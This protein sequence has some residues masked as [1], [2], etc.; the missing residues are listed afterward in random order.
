MK[1]AALGMLVA[2]AVAADAFAHHSPIVFDRSRE[3]RIE[4][5]VTEFKWSMPHSWIHLDVADA[6]GKVATWSVEMNPASSL[7]RRGW[8]S[9]TI[10]AGDKVSVLVYP[11]RNDEKGGQYISITLPDG[12]VLTERD[13]GVVAPANPQRSP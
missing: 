12:K 10:K 8:R 2:L 7:A 13:D 9:T 1:R 5:V 4:G 3:V 6:T 11:L